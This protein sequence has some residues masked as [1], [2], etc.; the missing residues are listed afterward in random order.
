MTIP[1]NPFEPTPQE[2]GQGV[3]SAEGV[4]GD[5][6]SPPAPNV[7]DEVPPLPPAPSVPDEVPTPSTPSSA[8]DFP[9]PP[10]IPPAGAQVPPAAGYPAYQPAAGA[11]AVQYDV[12]AAFSFGWNKFKAN[13]GAILAALALYFVGLI[14]ATIV[15]GGIASIGGQNGGFISAIFSAVA[16]VGLVVV[17]FW[18]QAAVARFALAITDGKPS[19]LSTIASTDN[20]GNVIATGLIV[21]LASAVASLI[22]FGIPIL[23]LIVG[24]FTQFAVYY[25]VDKNTAPIES[26]KSSISLVQANIVPALLYAVVSY[27]AY[28]VGG[29]LCLVGLLVALPVITIAGAYT[30]RVLNREPVAP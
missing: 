11:A 30:Y 29:L 27:V 28:I 14:I 5:V 13:A 2:P 26:I 15:L 1:P 19:P 20:L 23:S 22:C 9:P 18:V 12:G 6:P 3:P 17:V 4:P 7:P 25:V 16:I 10:P 24:F 21:G 8:G